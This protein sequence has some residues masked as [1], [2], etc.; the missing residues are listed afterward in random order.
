MNDTQDFDGGR[1]YSFNYA[2]GKG[3]VSFEVRARLDALRGTM[4]KSTA[5]VRWLRKAPERAYSGVKKLLFFELNLSKELNVPESKR[6]YS[7][8]TRLF[9]KGG[10]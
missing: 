4:V 7:A 8:V 3:G 10:H 6:L 9:H 2:E 1:G 5:D